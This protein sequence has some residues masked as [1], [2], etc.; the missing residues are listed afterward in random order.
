MR[1]EIIVRIQFPSAA[2]EMFAQH[3]TVHYSPSL[4]EFEKA[5]EEFPETRALVTNGSIGVTGDQLRR[6]KKLEMVLTQGVGY[7]NVDMAA[8]KELGLVLTTGKGTNAFSVADHGMA[9]LLAIARNIPSIDRRVRQ[10]DWLKS[11]GPQPLAWKK[12]LGI[13]G[14]GEIGLQ[15]AQRAAGFDMQISYHNRSKRSDVSYA[16][17]ETPLELARDSDFV[18]VVMPGG[19]ET[20]GLVG[21]EFLDA[22]GP[23]GHLINIGRGSIVDTD[24]LI[25]ALHEKRIAGAALDV[26]AGEPVVTQELIGAPNLIITPHMAGRSPESVSEAMNRVVNNLRAHFAGEPLVSQIA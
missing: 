9:L 22:L 5:I 11:R 4:E 7:E 12:R 1:P 6:L 23:K 13:L 2:L 16:Y 24:E 26:V 3:F 8:V 17:K 25:K 19:P 10:G 14:L 21:R 15:I 18:I 20:R